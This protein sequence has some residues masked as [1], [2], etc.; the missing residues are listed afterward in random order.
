L[1]GQSPGQSPPE[2]CEEQQN[3]TLGAPANRFWPF[4]AAG[5]I[6]VFYQIEYVNNT[7]RIRL[8]RELNTSKSG[9]NSTWREDQCCMRS[10]A[11]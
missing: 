7:I 4:V 11:C 9:V 3:L 8:A 2:E 10:M 1:L 6:Q 5:G